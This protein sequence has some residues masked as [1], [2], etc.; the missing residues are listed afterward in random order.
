MTFGVSPS[1]SNTK[2]VPR[3]AFASLPIIQLPAC[4]CTRWV[5]LWVQL[6]SFFNKMFTLFIGY[7]FSSDQIDEG[8]S[9][10]LKFSI[11][12]HVLLWMLLTTWYKAPVAGR[13]S[14]SPSPR[15]VAWRKWGE[16]PEATSRQGQPSPRKLWATWFQPLLSTRLKGPL[17]SSKVHKFSPFESPPPNV[18]SHGD[19][20]WDTWNHRIIKIGKDL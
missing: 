7:L 19:Q 15:Q 3:N 8:L 18:A 10:S 20:L 11:L 1:S 13:C 4:V 6:F 16:I 14:H 5:L 9:S 12:H 17:F 2:K